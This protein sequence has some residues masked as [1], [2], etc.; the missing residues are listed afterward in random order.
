MIRQCSW[1]NRVLGEIEPLEDERITHT[2]CEN[3]QEDLVGSVASQ[4]KTLFREK[5]KEPVSC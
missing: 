5:T 4:R 1:C 2:I 3:C